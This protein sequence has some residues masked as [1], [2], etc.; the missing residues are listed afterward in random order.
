MSL[1][2]RSSADRTSADRTIPD[3]TPADRRTS[4]TVKPRFRLRRAPLSGTA[5]PDAPAEARAGYVFEPVAPA[6]GGPVDEAMLAALSDDMDATLDEELFPTLT[7]VIPADGPT[8]PIARTA[9][10]GRDAGPAS[11]E[12][13]ELA[14]ALAA[15]D[16]DDITDL[17]DILDVPVVPDATA[18]AADVQDAS[19]AADAPADVADRA[20][21]HRANWDA[22]LHRTQTE[23]LERLLL[24][25]DELIDVQ[26]R[27]A[28]AAELAGRCDELVAET[29]ARFDRLAADLQSAV[30][31]MVSELV[32]RM[33]EDELDR[34]RALP[35]SL[36]PTSPPAGGTAPTSSR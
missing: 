5:S 29:R 36:P 23:L 25:S 19:G 1:N 27:H 3:R 12:P 24:R 11:T 34:M 21:A 7:E 28:L 18:A 10:D 26:L 4:S 30:S 31:S 8:A 35:T 20:V 22:A 6:A 33:V 14:D 17:T 2:P 9:F 16:L 13:L 15:A 32:V